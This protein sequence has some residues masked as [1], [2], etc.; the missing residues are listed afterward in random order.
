MNDVRFAV[1]KPKIETEKAWGFSDEDGEL[2][3]VAKSQASLL[4]EIHRG[5]KVWILSVAQ[6]LDEK[7]NLQKRIGIA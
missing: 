2:V 6:W 4:R 7:E 1:A 3:W 5:A